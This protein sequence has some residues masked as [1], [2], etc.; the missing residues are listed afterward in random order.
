MYQDRKKFYRKLEQARGSKVIAYVTG[1]RQGLEAQIHPEV[2]DLFVDH[3]DRFG[4][5]IPKLSLYLYSPGGVTLAGWSLVNLIRIFADEFEVIIPFKAH[6]TATLIALGADKII[7]T[8][9]ATLGPIDP[10]VNSPYNP[11]IPGVTAPGATLPVSVESVAGFI[12][13]AKEHL[14]E[15]ADLKEI[16]LRLANSVHPLA[17]GNV[18]RSRMQIQ[19]LARDLLKVHMTDTNQIENIISFL[20][21]ESGSHDYTINRREAKDRLHL[22]VENPDIQLY[23]NVIK[24]I[25]ADLK[26]ELE[27]DK[28]FN[29][30]VFLGENE[31]RQYRH[32]QA[33]V[34]SAQG[35]T[36]KFISEGTLKRILNP[37]PIP[38]QPPIMLMH[39]PTFSGW[40]HGYE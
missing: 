5:P 18:Q 28:P 31:A 37:Q 10:T 24:K 14:G 1:D 12:E 19:K 39:T 4:L 34:E 17:L 32:I 7:M 38:G 30:E 40:R 2:L 11:T 3:L 8:K 33:F 29:A 35:G 20:C 13:L 6:S 27:L 22:P 21:K 25:Y 15:K 26:Q 16:F 9:Q 23:N 36:H